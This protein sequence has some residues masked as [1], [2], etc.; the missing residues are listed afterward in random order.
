E[1]QA[2]WKWTHAYI[3]DA[4]HAFAL[5]SQNPS[6]TNVIYNVG[7]R[8]TPS[9]LERIAQIGGILD[10]KGE[11]VMTEDRDLAPH[12]QLPGYFDQ[13]WI[14]DTEKIRR[15]LNYCEQTDYLEGLEVSVNWYASN[16]P[17]EVVGV[18]YSYDLEDLFLDETRDS[19]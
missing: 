5:V 16:R 7:E 6:R 12:L 10:W 13:D 1:F 8:E 3:P 9:T 19:D 4:A 2:E 15:E 14:Y 17:E 11:I 18:D